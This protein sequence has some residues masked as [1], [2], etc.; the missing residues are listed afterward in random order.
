ME[1]EHESGSESLEEYLKLAAE[2]IEGSNVEEGEE[3][4][5][6]MGGKAPDPIF[7]LDSGAFNYD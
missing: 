6:R 3:A 5:P 7:C 2:I 4:E 1:T